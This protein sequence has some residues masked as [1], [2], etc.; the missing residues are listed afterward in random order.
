MLSFL[1]ATVVKR[2]FRCRSGRNVFP[3]IRSDSR[4]IPLRVEAL[5]DRCLLSAVTTVP[6]SIDVLNPLTVPVDMFLAAQPKGNPNVVFLGDSIAEGYAFGT[7]V[8]VWS[9]FL[10]PLGA[11]DYGVGNQTT[12]TLLYQLWLG[13]LVGINPSAV[14]LIIGA[15][16][17]VEGDSPSATAAG[18]LADVNAIHHYLPAAE[19]LVLGVPP[20]GPRPN[21]PYRQ[22]ANQTDALVISM[23]AGDPRAAFVNIAPGLEQPDGTISNFVLF[24]NVHPTTLGYLG[25]TAVLLGPLDEA[26][27]EGI[28]RSQ[29]SLVDGLFG[30]AS[31]AFQF[32]WRSSATVSSGLRALIL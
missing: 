15:N 25:M 28:F 7:G 16:N 19:V 11:V 24:D 20:G 10:A 21:D 5:E 8:P 22:L 30:E 3:V 31:L 4:S 6:S 18:I 27:L 23:L 12:Q 9:T 2:L 13:Q 32:G 14:V 17:V 26:W 1:F 29:M